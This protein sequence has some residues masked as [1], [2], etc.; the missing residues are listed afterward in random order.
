MKKLESWKFP[1]SLPANKV[2][3]QENSESDE[4]LLEAV[5][6]AGSQELGEGEKE[7]MVT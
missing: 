5:L 6:K 7:K 3:E 4:E 1:K 2:I